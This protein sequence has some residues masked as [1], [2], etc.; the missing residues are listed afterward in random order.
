MELSDRKEPDVR[1]RRAAETD[2]ERAA[3]LLRENRLP[4][5]GFRESLANGFVAF[6]GEELAGCVTLE[7][8]GKHA[9][10]RSLAV[11]AAARGRG[12]GLDLT[13]RAL[14]LARALG[15][16]DVYLLT[17]TARGFFPRFGFAA[18]DRSAAPSPLRD[19]VEFREACPESATLM[20]ARLAS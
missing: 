2:F 12:L 4:L 15:A 7:L 16:S 13:A 10:L 20:H 18:E 5:E 11:S 8:H 9:L 17:E 1:V 3:E 19:S 14:E 6:A